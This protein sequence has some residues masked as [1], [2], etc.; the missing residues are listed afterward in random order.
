MKILL[1]G[2]TGFVGSELLNE[3]LSRQHSV[4]ALVRDPTK[5][6]E[7]ESRHP[8]LRLV[9]GD[10][11]DTR[12]LPELA[13]EHELMLVAYSVKTDP[14]TLRARFAE[15]VDSIVEAA[16]ASGT[17][18]IFVGG[19]GS[20]FLPDGSQLVDSPDFPADWK[21]LAEASRDALQRFENSEGVNWTLVSPAPNLIPGTRTGQFRLGEN[22]VLFDGD[23]PASIST[24]DL[25]VAILDEAE[26]PQFKNRRFTAGY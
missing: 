14:T 18:V 3:S 15:A 4:T 24:A 16:R 5:L 17:R 12:Q 11:L 20:L 21:P 19:A 10:L 25:A 9:M 7:Q 23:Q 13:E 26:K 22:D 8:N 6:H 1:I 2:G